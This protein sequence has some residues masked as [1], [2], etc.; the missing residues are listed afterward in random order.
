[1]KQRLVVYHANCIDG[2]TAAW[3][4][5]RKFG[6]DAEY[7]PANYGEPPPD[8]TGRDLLIVDFSYAREVLLDL[9]ARAKSLLVLDHHKTAMEALT[10]LP[11]AVF[12]MQRS[13]AGLTWDT[14]CS[15]VGPRPWLVDYVEDRDLWRFSLERSKAVNAFV[16][17]TK[18]RDFSDWSALAATSRGD[19]ANKGDAILA[20]IDHYVEATAASARRVSFHG[21]DGI[22]IVNAPSM[23]IS[24]L[25]GH[26][27]EGAPFAIGWSQRADGRYAY[28]L[29]SRGDGG[30]DVAEIAK[31]FGGG[32]HRNAAGFVL[33]APLAV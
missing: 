28:S 26:L 6:D 2:F 10:G 32:G 5:W 8:A 27:A 1:M 3:A 33:A 20:F 25:V 21:F 17:A 18:R 12:D 24:E 30:A 4:A 19:A 14:L 22:P 23:M 7:L 31:H 13:G 9:H 15:D 29:R 16:G 11:F